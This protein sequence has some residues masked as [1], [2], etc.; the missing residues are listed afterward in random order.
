MFLES[1]TISWKIDVSVSIRHLRGDSELVCGRQPQPAGD[2]NLCNYNHRC[3]AVNAH[4]SA[5][6]ICFDR[7][8]PGWFLLLPSLVGT[9]R[10]LFE[11]IKVAVQQ[12]HGDPRVLS[13]KFALSEMVQAELVPGIER[14]NIG[15]VEES[16]KQGMRT[17]RQKSS[18]LSVSESIPTSPKSTEMLFSIISTLVRVVL[19]SPFEKSLAE[20]A[21]SRTAKLSARS[22]T[23]GLSV[24]DEFHP[25][26]LGA[27]ILRVIRGNRFVRAETG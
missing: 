15:G 14:A 23:P 27:A 24:F 12:S 3:N 10:R 21:L 25:T 2:I 18:R 9:V 4:R 13:R 17:M 26:V 6:G 11:S 5:L 19:F 16:R 22:E 20:P 7:I 8:V 1:A